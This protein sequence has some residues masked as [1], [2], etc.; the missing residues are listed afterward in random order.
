[1][2]QTR[3]VVRSKWEALVGGTGDGAESASSIRSRQW[4]EERD[5]FHLAHQAFSAEVV[6]GRGQ[7]GE[8]NN[9]KRRKFESAPAEQAATEAGGGRPPVKASPFSTGSSAS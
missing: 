8:G 1:M 6:R 4:L 5:I 3:R 2:G 7:G 9:G